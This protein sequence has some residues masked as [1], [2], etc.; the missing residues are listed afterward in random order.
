LAGETTAS[1]KLRSFSLQHDHA[2]IANSLLK[3]WQWPISHIM[4]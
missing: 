3:P 4:S 1:R 2:A